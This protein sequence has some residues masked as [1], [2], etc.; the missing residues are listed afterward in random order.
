MATTETCTRDLDPPTHQKQCKFVRLTPL[1]SV[2]HRKEI[3][4]LRE[5][6]L[7]RRP[8]VNANQLMQPW[9]TGLWLGRDALSD[10]HL[11]GTAAGSHE[12]QSSTPSSRT[13]KV[14]AGSVECHA[15]HTVVSTSESSRPT[16]LAE[17]NVRGT[18]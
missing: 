11:I 6:V 3:L 2:R 10:E 16:S 17:T 1:R 12:K 4:P 18:N 7:A 15:L 14:G 5:Q 13:S 8:G 9:V